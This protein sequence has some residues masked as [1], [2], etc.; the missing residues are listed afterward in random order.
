MSPLLPLHCRPFSCP[1]DPLP[2]S[3]HPYCRSLPVDPEE[4]NFVRPVPNACYSKV[5][6]EPL[7]NP[8][9][10][11]ASTQVATYTLTR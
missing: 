6:P 5:T 4:R 1:T 8:V 11:A 7:R 9:L 10:I 3:L 2:S